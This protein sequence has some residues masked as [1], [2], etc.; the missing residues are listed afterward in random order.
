MNPVSLTGRVHQY[1]AS[2]L[3]MLCYTIAGG[4]IIMAAFRLAP[5]YVDDFT[6]RSVLSALDERDSIHKAS[7]KEVEGWI[8]KGFQ[9]N[10]IRDVPASAIQVRRKGGF[11]VADVNY[12][13][14]IDLFG[15]IDV[16][17][18]F[19]NSWKIKQQ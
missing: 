8:G 9:V 2:V 3:Q 13:R 6:V 15:N 16:V 12:E 5:A 11:L 19:E 17:L 4:F 7:P 10:G 1:G 18:S 14:R